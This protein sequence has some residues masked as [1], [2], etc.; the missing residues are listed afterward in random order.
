MGT[1]SGTL[2]LLKNIKRSEYL[3][4]LAISSA[5]LPLLQGKETTRWLC[6]KG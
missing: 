5:V 6:K 4:F 2:T 1:I 3:R